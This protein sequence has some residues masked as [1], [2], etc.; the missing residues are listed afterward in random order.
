MSSFRMRI[1][2]EHVV[3]C[4]QGIFVYQEQMLKQSHQDDIKMI[5]AFTGRKTNIKNIHA[6]GS[7]CFAYVQVK[8]KLDPHSEEGI[9]VGSDTNSPS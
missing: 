4:S 8:K 9:F 3:Q 5:E 7:T 2:E 6:F 1:T